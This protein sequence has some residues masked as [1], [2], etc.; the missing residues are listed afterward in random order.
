T[1]PEISL[2]SPPSTSLPGSGQLGA[3]SPSTTGSV[4]VHH[5]LVPGTELS[6]ARYKIERLVAAGGMGAVYRAVDTRF[7]RPCAVK[8]MLDEFRSESERVQAVEWFERE[9]KLLFDL[10]H[11]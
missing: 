11:Q 1:L 8:E 7:Q 10:S 9:A 4:G 3:M 5:R 2:S 6:S